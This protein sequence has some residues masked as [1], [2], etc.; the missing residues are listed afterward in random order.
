MNFSEF[1]DA[2]VPPLYEAEGDIPRCPPGYKFDKNQMMCVPKSPKDKVGQNQVAKDSDPKNSPPF[3]V[4]GRSG[5][6]GD[7]YAW[8]EKPT[9]Q[10]ED[11]AIR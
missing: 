8:E 4:W 2:M 6:N 5:M 7:G 1:L 11:G 9:G 3:N 10:T